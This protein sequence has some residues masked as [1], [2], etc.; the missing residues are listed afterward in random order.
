MNS[1]VIK[2]P[3]P[4]L[5]IEVP[6]MKALQLRRSKRK[7]KPDPISM[8]DIS[9]ILW[10]ACGMTMQPGKRSKSRRTA[11]S[12]SNSQE[13][14]VYT[15]IPEGVFLYEELEHCLKL[16]TD[17][18]IREDI[19]TQ[20]MMK[21][22]PLGLVYVSDTSRLKS[23]LAVDELRKVFVSGTDTGFISQN[24]YLY[25]AAAGLNTCVL[26]FVDRDKVHALMGLEEHEKVVYSQVV[27]Q[28]P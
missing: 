1:K 10:S 23:Y 20:K 11:P 24:V 4:Q 26:G 28:E 15:A 25:C 6:L 2:L 22:A 27:G 8:Q 7:W 3:P 17:T 18:D 14:R 21:K 12:S 19:G 13:I 5:D 16:Q 9:N